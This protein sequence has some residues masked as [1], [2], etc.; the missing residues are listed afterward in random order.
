MAKKEKK[1]RKAKAETAPPAEDVNA[2]PPAE[3][4]AEAPEPADTGEEF[5]DELTA[6]AAGFTG[7][8]IR[9]FRTGRNRIGRNVPRRTP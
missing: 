6:L 9:T 8:P 4:P 7:R 3:D 2:A 1:A 5:D